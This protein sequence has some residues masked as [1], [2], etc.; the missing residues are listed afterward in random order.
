MKEIWKA[1]KGFEK[2]YQISNHGRL[3]SLK[4]TWMSG[5]KSKRSHP[6]MI[7]KT[8]IIKGYETVLLN[9]AGKH[10]RKIHRLVAECF[11][12]NPSNKKNVNHKDGNK[13]NNHVENLEWN[14]VKENEF[15]AMINGLKARGEKHGMCRLT[16]NKVM[17]IRK[18]CSMGEKMVDIATEFNISV[19]H[20]SRIYHRQVWSHV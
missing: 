1:V 10:L 19:A 13:L 6:E 7:L 8:Q 4:R 2:Y 16:I 15:H 11:I 12:E 9:D 5:I 18:L 14:T 17:M 3:K 20:V